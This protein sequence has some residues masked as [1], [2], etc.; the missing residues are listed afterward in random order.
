MEK[1][2]ESNGAFMGLLKVMGPFETMDHTCEERKGDGA[3]EGR[4]HDVR[5]LV[6][7]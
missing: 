7:T 6:V 4:D 1:R 2:G 5:G 3:D